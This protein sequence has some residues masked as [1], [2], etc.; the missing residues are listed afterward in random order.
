[1]SAEELRRRVEWSVDDPSPAVRA[2][3]VLGGLFRLASTVATFGADAGSDARRPGWTVPADPAA[4]LDLGAVTLWWPTD[5][6]SVPVQATGHGVWATPVGQPPRPLDVGRWRVLGAV[7][8]G[9]TPRRH[10]EAEWLLTV[11]DGAVQGTLS[12]A[13]LALAWIGHLAG[14][15][16]PAR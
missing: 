6:P 12:G 11:S 9:R 5:A 15:P 3:W 13:W 4:Y 8:A 10:P 1:M 16:E 7:P 2:G 14:W